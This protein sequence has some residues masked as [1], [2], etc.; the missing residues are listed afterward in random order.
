MNVPVPFYSEDN[1]VQIKALLPNEGWS[2]SYGDWLEQT[3]RGE[4][5]VIGG[6]NVP[7][8]IEVEPAS[9][10]AW[11]KTKN[12]PLARL[13]IMKYCVFALAAN[14]SHAAGSS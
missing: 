14:L 13:S 12:Q 6:G 10:E 3:E 5:A 7:V 1:F 4:K 11:C 9:F 8:R 2:R